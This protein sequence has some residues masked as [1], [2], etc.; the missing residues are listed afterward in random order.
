ML[1]TRGQMQIEYLDFNRSRRLN[2]HHTIA[3]IVAVIQSGE[4]EQSD[5]PRDVCQSLG[6]SRSEIDELCR[7]IDDIGCTLLAVGAI[8]DWP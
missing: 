7:L 4:I 2:Y 1:S 8:S 3:T 6:W 5:E